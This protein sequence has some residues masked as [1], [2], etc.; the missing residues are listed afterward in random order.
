MTPVQS[1]NLRAVGYNPLAAVLTIAL[2]GDRIYQYFRVPLSVYLGLTQAESPGKYFHARI[3][4]R[5]A[6][7]KIAG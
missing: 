2:H 3:K 4:H 7:R 6:C 1:S 5:Y